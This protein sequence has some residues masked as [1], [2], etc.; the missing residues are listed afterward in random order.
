MK[1]VLTFC[2]GLASFVHRLARNQQPQPQKKMTNTI[3]KVIFRTFHTGEII[4][5]FPELPGDAHGVYCMSYQS[6]GQHGMASTDLSHCT[7][8]AT[9]SESRSLFNELV[10]IGYDLK[11]VKRVTRAMNDVRRRRKSA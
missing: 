7:R 1:I 6:I 9:D 4:A 8:P 2:D 5:L 10:K 11:Q 3:T